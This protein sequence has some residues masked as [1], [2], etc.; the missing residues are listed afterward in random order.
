[1]IVLI[2]TNFLVIMSTTP[3]VSYFDLAKEAIVALK[4]RTGSSLQAIKA[5]IAKAHPE[6]DFAAVSGICY[7]F[8]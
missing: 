4:E 5:H 6:V 7:H 8:H 1:M 2:D 3:K